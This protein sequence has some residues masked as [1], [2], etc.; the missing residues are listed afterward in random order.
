MR[1]L[2]TLLLLLDLVVSAQGSTW[3]DIAEKASRSVVF[4]RGIEENG[5]VID[6]GSGF[7]L[8]AD[9]K[10]ATNL[11]VIRDMQSGHVQLSTGEVFNEFTVLA[12]DDK[13]DLAI[14]KIPS[15][16]LPAINLGDSNELK[17]G[18]PVMAIGSP[19]EL[20]GTMTAGI[21]SAIREDPFSGG[22]RVI[23]TDA[24][25]NPGNSG[26]P[27]LN[28]KGEVI[29]IVS[30][31]WRDSPGLNFALPINDVRNMMSSLVAPMTLDA[32]RVKLRVSAEVFSKEVFFKAENIPP[33]K[34]SG[35]WK[36]TNGGSVFLIKDRGDKIQITDQTHPQVTFDARWEG[37][38]VIAEV[39]SPGH[40]VVRMAWRMK[41]G[42]HLQVAQFAHSANDSNEVMLKKASKALDRP[43]ALWIRLE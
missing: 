38:V 41:D 21:V 20:Q 34:L 39:Y 8:S 18:E 17:T 5:T 27:L 29:G 9:G 12:F 26:G 11:H 28:T 2:S 33:G 32:M 23:Q 4:L 40:H 16:D 22:Y 15:F 13:K 42:D 37:E 30:Y 6:F 25:F 31:K 1:I 19:Q 36:S 35:C 10:I 24:S 3:D 7:L 43:L 14:I